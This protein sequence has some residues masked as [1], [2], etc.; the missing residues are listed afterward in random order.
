MDSDEH[1]EKSEMKEQQARAKAKVLELEA[2]KNI[3]GGCNGRS[4]DKIDDAAELLVQAGNVLKAAKLYTEAVTDFTKAADLYSQL[5]Q[6][7]QAARLYKEVALIYKRAKDTGNFAFYVDLAISSWTVSGNFSTAASLQQQLAEYL[8]ENDQSKALAA[9]S[10][11]QD[12]AGAGD[13]ETLMKTCQIKVADCQALQGDF[14]KASDAYLEVAQL[15][16]NSTL[17]K[18][19]IE[20]LCTKSCLCN[21]A[22]GDT[23]GA[24]RALERCSQMALITKLDIL[25]Q[26]VTACSENDVEAFDAAAN[27]LTFVSQWF[28]IMLDKAKQVLEQED[29]DGV[30]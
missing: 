29:D 24:R 25:E 22:Q 7:Y 30:L 2:E 5:D 26:L 12:L 17:G 20:E 8:E 15:E 11:T 13:S 27:R 6:G 16:K 1:T 3:E 21:L 28:R 9:W 19:K 23:V 18:Y 14:S 4:R 10:K